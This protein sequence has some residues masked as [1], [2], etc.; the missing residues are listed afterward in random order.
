MGAL[1]FSWLDTKQW[2]LQCISIGHNTALHQTIHLVFSVIEN[3]FIMHHLFRSF[4]SSEVNIIKLIWL[5][6]LLEY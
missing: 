5:R 2:Y 1:F 4:L 3:G 6:S